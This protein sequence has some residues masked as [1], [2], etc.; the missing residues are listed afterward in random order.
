MNEEQ[1]VLGKDETVIDFIILETERLFLRE[2]NIDDTDAVYE[3]SG[4]AENTEYL[5]WGPCSREKADSFVKSRLV[6]QIEEPRKI[7]DFAVC[8]KSTGKLIGSM[9]LV[10]K[11]DGMQAD[12]GYILNKDHWGMG[13][14][15][16]AA[17]AFLSFAFLSLDLHRVSAKCDAENAASESVMKRLGMRFEGTMRSAAYVNVRGRKQWR[18]I[19]NYA[20]LQREYLSRL[21]ETEE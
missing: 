13:Y 17:K 1:I 2:F 20:L 7:Y 14:A 5:D 9:C 10:I 19:K 8:L 3:Y 11:G 21:A 6:S 12:L 16:E 4:S 18:S 15:T